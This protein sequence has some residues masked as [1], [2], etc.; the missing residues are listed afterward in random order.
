M[1]ALACSYQ[2]PRLPLF[3]ILIK[4]VVP[5]AEGTKSVLGIKGSPVIALAACF[6]AAALHLP[7]SLFGTYKQLVALHICTVDIGIGGFS[8]NPTPGDGLHIILINRH[9]QAVVKDKAL[10]FVMP[11]ALLFGIPLN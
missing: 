7:G 11:A 6:A 9:H 10:A 2:S 3:E 5:L 1:G 4:I 8:G